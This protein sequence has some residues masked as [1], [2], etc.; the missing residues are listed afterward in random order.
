M[1]PN[2]DDTWNVVH[3]DGSVSAWIA[4]AG[5]AALWRSQDVGPGLP[6][7]YDK[8]EHLCVENGLPGD[9]SAEGIYPRYDD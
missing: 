8:L 5:L 4:T 1:G 3:G 6:N 7:R 9:L 2:H